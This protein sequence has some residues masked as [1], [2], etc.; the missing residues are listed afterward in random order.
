MVGC[1]GKSACVGGF[2]LKQSPG[3]LSLIEK[4]NVCCGRKV[5]GVKKSYVELFFFL[6]G[7]KS[8]RIGHDGKRTFGVVKRKRFPVICFA[9]SSV[10]EPEP[11]LFLPFEKIM[12]QHR[13]AGSS[14]VNGPHI[15]FHMCV[16]V[17]IAVDIGV[18][19]FEIQ[20]IVVFFMCPRDHTSVKQGIRNHVGIQGMKRAFV[21]GIS[22]RFFFPAF[23][24]GHPAK[25]LNREGGKGIHQE[26]PQ[27]VQ[28]DE[29]C[30]VGLI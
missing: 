17:E 8:T 25:F 16:I 29:S 12:C 24:P 19:L 14:G 9:Q 4:L 7:K 27:A 11:F 5:L 15:L 23:F 3:A 26:R 1:H 10:P 18:Y 30:A 2:V 22:D 20:I 21:Y 28:H 6:I 13:G